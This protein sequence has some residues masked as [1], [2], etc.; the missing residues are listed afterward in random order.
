MK[1]FFNKVLS[2]ILITSIAAA[3]VGCSGGGTT[4]ANVPS[5]NA[6][7]ELLKAEPGEIVD[8]ALTFIPD[9]AEALVTGSS[10]LITE[11][12]ENPLC[13]WV[14]YLYLCGSDLE[15][16]FG[17]ATADF[18]EILS[19]KLPDT[20]KVL[21][22]TGGAYEWKLDGNDAEHNSIYEYNSEGLLKLADMEPTNM[23]ESQ[24]IADFI[25]FGKHEYPSNHSMLILWN[26]GGGT[27]GGICYDEQYSMDSLSL[28][29]L[30]TAF[31][32]AYAM[33]D[34]SGAIEETTKNVSDTGKLFDI[35]G[36]DACLMSNIDVI[37]AIEPYADW[38]IASEEQEPGNGWNYTGF[39]TQMASDTEIAP[40][41]LGH[42]VLDS[43]LA[44][45]EEYE[46]ADA[47]TLSLINMADAKALIETYNTCGD[48]LLQSTLTDPALIIAALSRSAEGAEKYGNNSPDEG[49]TNMIDLGN[50]IEGASGLDEAQAAALSSDLEKA[51]RYKVSG[52]LRQQGAG[53]SCY[54]PLDNSVR[55]L[56]NYE[57][58]TEPN[59]YRSVYSYQIR[60]QIDNDTLTYIE[61][62]GLTE[63]DIVVEKINVDTLGLEGFYS[64]HNDEGMYLDIGGDKAKYLS[65][66]R[67]TLSYLKIDP[68]ETEESGETEETKADSA[69]Q[70]EDESQ[71]AE[72]DDDNYTYTMFMV[73]FL[74]VDTA[75]FENG[76]FSKPYQTDMWTLNGRQIYTYYV[77]RSRGINIYTI[78]VIWNGR[79]AFLRMYENPATGEAEI[80]SV[81]YYLDDN[82]MQNRIV[83]KLKKGDTITTLIPYGDLDDEEIGELREY[84]TFTLS[85][86]PALTKVPLE[87]GIYLWTFEMN[88]PMKNR[89]E[90]TPQIYDIENGEVVHN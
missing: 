19:V 32:E 25:K 3:A 76:Y 14:I 30:A 22:E 47:A 9:S 90:S 24:T 46:T 4:P 36:F 15:T 44:G 11:E 31:D 42:F 59:G 41:T 35:V 8:A 7:K 63:D 60:E 50:L 26:H 20:V 29:E 43:F 1:K 89:A 2:S 80:Y 82:Y 73:G 61:G 57:G 56:F 38:M 79:E 28:V 55:S 77:S 67:G 17:S 10:D 87:D 64:S 45:C 78:P 27:L 18:Q 54:Y 34:N 37:S 72:D 23:G 52:P 65:K 39:L 58:V 51:V 49:F 33:L 5:K 40:E 83:E 71:E 69:A 88:D 66:V 62:I 13:D 6:N 70:A 68:I 21:I 16:N 86:E 53:I 12:A 74:P 85:E 75:D 81:N 48:K 84:E